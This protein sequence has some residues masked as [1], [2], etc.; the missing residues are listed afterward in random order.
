MKILHLILG[1]LAFST[2]LV[3]KFIFYNMLVEIMV[4]SIIIDVLSYVL[5]MLLAI[6]LIGAVDYWTL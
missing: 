1:N 4:R 6:I 2:F 3:A 5:S